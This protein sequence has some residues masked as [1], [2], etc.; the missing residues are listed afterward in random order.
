MSI[1]KLN[2]IDHF[3]LYVSNKKQA[4]AWYKKVLGFEICKA[5]DLWDDDNGPLT[6][7]DSSETIHLALFK[8]KEQPPSTSIAFKSTGSQFILWE[9][10]LLKNDIEIRISDHQIAWSLYFKDPDDNMHEITTYDHQVVNQSIQQGN[11][12]RST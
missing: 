11:N 3:H 9:K 1:P 10:H 12:V 8:R 6:I 4:A 7:Q 2:G 5:L